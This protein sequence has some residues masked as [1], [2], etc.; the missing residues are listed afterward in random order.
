[1]TA[2]QM[3]YARQLRI[4]VDSLDPKTRAGTLGDLI[5]IKLASRRLDKAL[6][7]RTG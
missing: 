6:A 1:M 2:P 3:N 5:S 4:P 7:R